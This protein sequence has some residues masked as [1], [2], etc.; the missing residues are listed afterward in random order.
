MNIWTQRSIELANQH[1]YLDQLFKVYPLSA[2]EKRDLSSDVVEKLKALLQTRDSKGLINLLLDQVKGNGDEKHPFPIKYSYV[3]Y[4]KNDRSAIERNPKT[5]ERI[6]SYL[7]EMGLAGILEKTSAPKETNRQMGQLFKNYIDQATLGLKVT[8]DE[9]SFLNSEED[10]IFNCSDSLGKD[11]AKRVLGYRRDKGLDFIAKVKETYL[12]GEAKFLSDYGGNQN[13]QI[14]D[15]F[16]TLT[17]GLEPTD[18]CVKKLAILDGVCYIKSKC[19]MH[20]KITNYSG[21]GVILSATLLR[22]FLGSL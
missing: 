15:A 10:I 2:N 9:M 3:S 13:D 6:A 20:K 14:Q 8:K 16:L 11:F 1:D 17:T 18:F 21:N 5:V 4:L 19:K 22:E 12:I 7:Y